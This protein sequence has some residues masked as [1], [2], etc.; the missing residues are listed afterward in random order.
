ML[1]TA[2]YCIMEDLLLSVKN[3]EIGFRKKDVFRNVSFDIKRKSIFGIIGSS[4]AGKST[5]IKALLGLIKPKRGSI[6]F[7]SD[8]KVFRKFKQKVGYSSQENSFYPKLTVEENMNFFANL[9]NMD[10]QTRKTRIIELLHIFNLTHNR[11]AYA[12]DLSGGMK[13]RLDLA[14]SL[15]H[16]PEI[17]I[18]DEPTNGLDI[19]L[20]IELWN[21]ILKINSEG[22]TIIVTTHNLSDVE[23]YCND[24]CLIYRKG[25][26]NKKEV[27]QFGRNHKTSDL[28]SLM[29]K[30]YKSENE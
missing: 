27:E 29:Y 12:E 30:L 11:H 23:K 15:V 19:N 5:L 18:L 25:S 26:L 22:T 21:Y 28:E 13:R 3:L 2:D 10:K 14:I 20:Q 6:H 8:G 9:Y 16:K 1:L 17:L 4:G 7:Y 24:I